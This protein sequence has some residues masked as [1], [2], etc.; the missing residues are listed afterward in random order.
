[1]SQNRNTLLTMNLKLK[2][3]KR[4]GSK[5][6]GCRSTS[7]MFRKWNLWFQNLTRKK[8]LRI[9]KSGKLKRKSSRLF[10]KI[11]ISS[12]SLNFQKTSLFKENWPTPSGRKSEEINWD[13]LPGR[14]RR[15]STIGKWRNLTDSTL[16]GL[17]ILRL[18][19][20][21][22]WTQLSKIS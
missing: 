16:S 15:L 5:V 21:W 19:E 20:M 3:I 18:T 4:R 1:M 8:I 11:G 22:D 6:K 10:R 17:K 12:N 13:P 14:L 7:R 9:S 2:P